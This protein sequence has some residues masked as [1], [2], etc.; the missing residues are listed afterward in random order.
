MTPDPSHILNWRRVNAQIT[1]SGQPSASEFAQ[2]KACGTRHVINLGPYDNAGALEDEPGTLAAL[3]LGYTYIPVDFDAPSEADFAGFC[4]ALDALADTPVHIHCIYNA[5]V[6]AFMLRRAQEGI[7]GDPQAAEG[8]MEGIWRA[9]GV[10]AAFLGQT[11]RTHLPN[12]YAGYDY[13]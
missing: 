9:G 4:A 11:D 1:L 13:D 3:G 10:W 6:T 12:T 2:I 8:M 5:R 7:G